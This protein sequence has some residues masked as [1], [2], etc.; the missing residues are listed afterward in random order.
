LLKGG[1]P[2]INNVCKQ[3]IIDWQRGN[4]PYFTKPPTAEE[5]EAE[6][7]EQTELPVIQG[8]TQQLAKP[9]LTESG[10]QDK[11]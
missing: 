6:K 9:I 3:I 5:R 8:E 10:E 2:D 4:I 1:E 7:K 11:E